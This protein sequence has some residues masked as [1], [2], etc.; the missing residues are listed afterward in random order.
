MDPSALPP[1]PRGPMAVQI[2]QWLRD[3]LG[4][5]DRAYAQFG[6]IFTMPQPGTP[7]VLISGAGPTETLF[8][9]RRLALPGESELRPLLGDRAVLLLSGREHRDRRRILMPPFAG[10]TMLAWGNAIQAM[11]RDCMAARE[12][13]GGGTN[14]R[15]LMQEITLNVM[16]QIVFGDHE[17]PRRQKLRRDVTDRMLFSS[18]VGAVLALWLPILQTRRWP[19][20][21]RTLDAQTACD[22]AFFAEIAADRAAPGNAPTVL[23]ILLEATDETG[24]PLPD[25]DIRDELMTMMVAGHENTATALS[26]AIYWVNRYPAVLARLRDELEALG[27]DADPIAVAKLPYLEAVCN[28]TLRIFPPV[29]MTLGRIAEEAMEIGGHPIPAGTFLRSSI[30]LT[31]QDPAVFPD[32][33]R[34][35]PDRFLG[36]SFHK[37]ALQPFGGGGRKCIGAGFALFE[38]KLILAEMVR[39]WD[40]RLSDRPLR[41]VRR[42]GLLAPDTSFTIH[43]TPR[44]AR[45]PAP[46]RETQPCAA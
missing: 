36:A 46:V 37:F 28:E 5:L 30:Y 24:A 43:P 4:Y 44:P 2:A 11:T 17:G 25:S 33:K 45:P 32:P 34:F 26:W 39:H 3:P 19:A 13:A 1:G 6:P 23:R 35:D 9:D 7:L 29:M 40:V 14:V 21:R 12:R 18:T 42:T 10:G 20:W 38:M 31:H 16:L 41:A 22:Q 8:T 27:E 15:D